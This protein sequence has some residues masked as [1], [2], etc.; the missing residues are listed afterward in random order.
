M[1]PIWQSLVTTKA[2]NAPWAVWSGAK[3][4]DDSRT[5]PNVPV[6][7]GNG[8]LRPNLDKLEEGVGNGG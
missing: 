5:G 4:S 1:S 3:S 8:Q 7:T 6:H 2:E